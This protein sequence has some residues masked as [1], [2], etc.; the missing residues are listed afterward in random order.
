MVRKTIILILFASMANFSLIAKKIPSKEHVDRFYSTK[1]KVVL[2]DKPVGYNI[3]LRQAVERY[4]T[5]TDYEF[6]SQKEFNEQKQ[7]KDFSFLVL[8]ETWF[9]KDNK[10]VYYYFLNLVLGDSAETLTELPELVSIP[11]SYADINPEKHF[12]K[13]NTFVRFMQ[14][15]ITRMRDNRFP[16]LLR[17][18]KYYH[19]NIPKVRK[20]M[21][22]WIVKEDLARSIR[23]SAAVH[24]VYPYLVR[25]VTHDQIEK[26]IDT[27]KS[28]VVYLHK[29]GPEEEKG[30][31]ARCYKII[32]G[33]ADTRVYYYK[34]H[35]IKPNKPDGFLEKD[36]KRLNRW[37]WF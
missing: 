21:E 5:I 11:L 17:G 33:I 3:F 16:F 7:N 24:D 9:E 29:V 19:K 28:N 30:H 23:D 13:L 22:L 1:T 27:R 4:W 10:P 32:F 2:E 26:A 34:H 36:F 6:I 37:S 8:M 15:H 18:M 12:Y 20:E 31:K 35:M 14:D 25:Y